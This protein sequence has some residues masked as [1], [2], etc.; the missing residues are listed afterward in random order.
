MIHGVR[1]LVLELRVWI[2]IAL[3]AW[4]N[5]HS[6][7]S[8]I[9][10]LR[11]LGNLQLSYMG[12]DRVRK[13]VKVDERYFYDLYTPGWPSPIFDASIEGEMNR[14]IPIKKATH[15]F[16]N[17]FFAI[18]KKC[19]LQCEHCFEW[20]ALNGKERLTETDL[21]TIVRRFQKLGTGQI[22]LSGGEPMLRYHE[23]LR[24]VKEHNHL[25][26]FWL[27]TSG[28]NVTAEYAKELKKA[29]LTGIA[30][31][32]DHYDPAAHNK[33][34]GYQ[35]AFDWAQ[36]AMQNARDA[37]LVTSLS[38]CATKEFVT[39]ENME[40]Y[41]ITARNLGATFIQILEPK[42]VGHYA[43][44][45]VALSEAQQKILESFM[46]R[47]NT[48][49]GWRNFPIVI[50]HGYYQRRTGCFSS[51][52]RNIYVDTDGDINPCP[53]CHRKQG[54]AFAPDFES[55]IAH[56]MGSG[57]ERFPSFSRPSTTKPYS[58]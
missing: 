8:C 57:C 32:L 54:S 21:A 7:R 14:V 29:G 48:H 30:V 38:V 31:S 43:G 56:M 42:A 46:I 44:K 39:E 9:K 20:N 6:I 36:R 51:G 17:I 49:P 50:Y 33:F 12:S 11:H 37:N 3:L 5:Y 18:T 16:T 58:A 19:P 47:M 53:F 35:R 55:T 13:S 26:D 25:S 24:L 15:R 40:K 52:D 27:L 1:G 45:D 41:A 22:H 4:R 23:I 34:R 28:L 10:V 2:H